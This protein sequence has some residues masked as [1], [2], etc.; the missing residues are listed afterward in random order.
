[1]STPSM[2]IEPEVG[3]SSPARIP[4]SVDFPEPDGPVRAAHS[5]RS[6]RNVN[7]RSIE[8]VSPPSG[9][10]L[11]R[12]MASMAGVASCMQSW[13]LVGCR[14]HAEDARFAGVSR[15]ISPV[16]IASDNERYALDASSL[17]GNPV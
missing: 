15:G 8:M 4:R 6:M 11:K 12:L 7:P 2:R 16:F 17:K 10:D 5:P 13:L 14:C 3:V 9:R 1:M